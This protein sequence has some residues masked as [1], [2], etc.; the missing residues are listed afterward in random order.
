MYVKS[1]YKR[2]SSYL[3]FSKE[4]KPKCRVAN[5]PKIKVDCKVKPDYINKGRI[6][7]P[8]ST[9]TLQFWLREFPKGMD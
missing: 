1:P 7:S 4:F 9:N 8:H 3:T 6:V 2:T 5:N